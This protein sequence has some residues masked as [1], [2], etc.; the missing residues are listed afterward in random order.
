[1]LSHKRVID[2]LLGR[3]IIGNP[4]VECEAQAELVG[5]NRV[6][7]EDLARRRDADVV[8][9]LVVDSRDNLR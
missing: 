2:G 5:E 3:E 1:M 4:R 7:G 6:E 8:W 9:E